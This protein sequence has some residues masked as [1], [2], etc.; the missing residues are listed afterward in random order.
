M[1][2]N[3]L[4]RIMNSM[5]RLS[6]PTGNKTVVKRLFGKHIHNLLTLLA[7]TAFFIVSCEEDPTSIG[8]SILPL[9]DFDSIVA[10]DTMSTAMYTMFSDSEIS[11]GSYSYYLGSL[12]DP[13][14]G[15]TE[16]GFVTQLQLDM[17]WPGYEI[18]S[19]D[20]V[21]MTIDVQDVVG[22]TSS[23]GMM[24]LYEINEILSS[25]SSYL[26][27]RDM[28]VERQITSFSIPPLE[29]GSDTVLVVDLPVSFGEYI[30]R[31]TSMLFKSNNIPDFR[32]YFKGLYFSYPQSD[33]YHMLYINISG[34]MPGSSDPSRIVPRSFSSIVQRVTGQ[35][36]LTSN[37]TITIYYTDAEDNDRVYILLMNNTCA[38]YS[39]F[40]HNYELAD[41]EKKIKYINE[42]IVDT[43]VYIQS[44]SGVY[45]KLVIPGLEV[46]RS[47][48][49]IAINKARII[50]PVYL[51]AD[52]YTEDMVP[53][54]LLARY[55]NSEGTKELLPDYSVDENYAFVDGTYS[56]VTDQYKINIASFV[57]EYYEGN[58][59]E[60]EIEIYLPQL[61]A[62]NLIVKANRAAD[63][64]IRFELVYTVLNED[65]K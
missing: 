62:D 45:S 24:N 41:P 34:L 4:I 17:E 49:S 32:T 53:S 11:S 35:V 5:I 8:G 9:S 33:N 20:S 43:L 54:G 25:D 19:V 63:D 21:K 7:A 18:A 30:L 38:K 1:K 64:G 46:L 39:H 2:M 50:L 29:E 22:E 65:Q 61:S 48:P 23:P 12:Y 13:Y 31:D 6:E 40:V 28:S 51:N 59:L 52:D 15:L 26:V 16:A 37:S 56:K 27:G 47:L 57:Q 42:P 60:P 3:I 14:F 36:S 55:T 10:T 58:I 44:M